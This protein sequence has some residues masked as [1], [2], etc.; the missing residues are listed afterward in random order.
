MKAV[1]NIDQNCMNFTSAQLAKVH[2]KH[3]QDI[4]CRLQNIRDAL[5]L[6]LCK[7]LKKIIFKIIFFM[8]FLCFY[9]DF[10]MILFTI[11]FGSFFL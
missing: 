7:E 8:I 6:R 2:R 5:E 9:F 10:F 4:K 11:F 1:E 3:W